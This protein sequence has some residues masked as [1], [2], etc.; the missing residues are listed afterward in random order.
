MSA[1]LEKH[2]TTK[3]PKVQNLWEIALSEGF[4][5]A[6]WQLP[7]TV[8][9]QLIID[10]S[11]RTSRMKV[12]LEEMP[13]GF[14]MSPFQGESLFIKNDL[15]YCFDTDNQQV[16]NTTVE[17]EV[18]EKQYL[19]YSDGIINTEKPSQIHP[20]FNSEKKNFEQYNETIFSEMVS[21]AITSIKKG[22]VQKVV[23]SRTKNIILPDTFEVIEA[24]KKL[25]VIYPNAFVSLVYLPEYQ[26]FWLGA[27]PETLVSMDKDDKFRTMSLAGTQSAIGE[28][29][30]VLSI[31]EILWTHKEIEEQAFVSRYIIE[32]FKKIRLREYY[33]S[34]PKTVQAGN[35]MHLRTD[36]M[37]DTQALNFPQ[38]GTV[39]I[40]LLHPTS[41]VCGMPKVPALRIIAEQE[42]H[43]RAFYSG[44]LG[45]VNVQKESHLFVNLRTM[46]II[47]NQATLYAGCGITEDSIPLKE[48]SETEMKIQTLMRV[49][50]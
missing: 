17:Q 49:I 18:F 16:N 38:L 32:C 35:L 21:N 44:F 1:I 46:K 7:K 11:G 23:L 39:M 36:Y 19:V 4:P 33:E 43:D 29:G 5:I 45:P 34:G 48:W 41:A 40:E 50:L 24:F 2:N 42:L 10:L 47:G 30:G 26:C 20:Y 13:S 12:D 25:C 28:S 37:V 3:S 22:E 31:N 27:T 9:K 14:V 6:L 15:Y 8:E